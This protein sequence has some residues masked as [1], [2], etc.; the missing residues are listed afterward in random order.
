M[1]KTP[2]GLGTESPGAPQSLA[3]PYQFKTEIG[4][5]SPGIPA[6][7]LPTDIVF[8]SPFSPLP[9]LSAFAIIL[10]TV[11]YGKDA[12]EMDEARRRP[13]R[14]DAVEMGRVSMEVR[15]LEKWRRR[16]GD[17]GEN[18]T[19]EA[20]VVCSYPVSRRNNHKE[21]SL[22]YDGMHITGSRRAGPRNNHR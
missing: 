12:D 21:L 9:L 22:R 18:M 6:E 20:I 17:S 11:T 13:D 10:P 16:R 7:S 15:E 4:K 8:Y 5:V 19:G 14:W 3:A 1:R 2:R